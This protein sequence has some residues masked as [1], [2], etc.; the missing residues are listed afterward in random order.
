MTAAAID[1]AI[2][3]LPLSAIV[4]PKD[5]YDVQGLTAFALYRWRMWGLGRGKGTSLSP[6]YGC[7]AVTGED[8]DGSPY[9]VSLSDMSTTQEV[10]AAIYPYTFPGVLARAITAQAR[11]VGDGNK[12]RLAVWIRGKSALVWSIVTHG[13]NTHDPREV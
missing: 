5:P 7:P 2:S 13:E 9:M 1:T 8:W 12:T 3:A 10:Q 4:D 11:K 6:R